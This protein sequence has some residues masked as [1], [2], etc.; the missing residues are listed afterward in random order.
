MFIVT[1]FA[2]ALISCGQKN[3]SSARGNN[4]SANATAPSDTMQKA[5]GADTGNTGTQAVL[6]TGKV[7]R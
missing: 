4:S 2:I 6:D 3:T 5:S 7:A 1:M